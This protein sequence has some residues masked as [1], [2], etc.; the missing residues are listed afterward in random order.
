M[1]VCVWVYTPDWQG[2]VSFPPVHLSLGHWIPAEIQLPVKAPIGHVRAGHVLECVITD[3]IND[4][5]HHCPPARHKHTHTP[6]HHTRKHNKHP[7]THTHPP[8]HTHTHTHT[9]RHT[10]L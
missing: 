5:T 2:P 8:T 7:H 3:H 10:Q 4:G 6:P 9:E 1:G